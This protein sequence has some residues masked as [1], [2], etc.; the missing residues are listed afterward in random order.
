MWQV[1]HVPSRE[2]E[3]ARHASRAL[4]TLQAS[5]RAIGIAFAVCWRCTGCGGCASMRTFPARLATLRDSAGASLPSGVRRGSW[6][7]GASCSASSRASARA[8]PG[9]PA[10][11]YAPRTTATAQRLADLRAIAARSATCS[12]MS[13]SVVLSAIDESRRAHRPGLGAVSQWDYHAGP[14]LAPSGLPAVRRSP[15]RS[16]GPG[17]DI[18]RPVR[19]RSGITRRFGGAAR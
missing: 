6:R 18:N 17:S 7:P 15:S 12:P 2:V 1:V 8:A 5:A 4:T 10:G 14:G 11:P 3:D 16:H 19:S 9:A 13:S